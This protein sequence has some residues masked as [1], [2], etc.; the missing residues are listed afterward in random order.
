VPLLAA[1]VAASFAAAA[2]TVLAAP[3]ADVSVPGSERSA[4]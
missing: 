1:S 3:A 4:R 2:P